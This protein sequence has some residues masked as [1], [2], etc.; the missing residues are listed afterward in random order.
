VH[1]KAKFDE[2]VGHELPIEGQA[3]ASSRQQHK[4]SRPL[5]G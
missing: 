5:L 2:L 3:C 4:V 1:L